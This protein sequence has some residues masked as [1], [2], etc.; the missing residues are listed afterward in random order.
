MAITRLPLIA[1]NW[2]MNGVKKHANKL[3]GSLAK[4][5]R[6]QKKQKFEML[7]CPPAP[8]I[9][10]VVEA[11]RGTGIAV[12]SQDC[13]FENAGAYTGEMSAELLKS[14]E[15]KYVILGH[16]ERRTLNKETDAVILNKATTA[17]KV[18]LRTIICI[19]E[20]L[21]QREAGRTKS[22]NRKQ[23][24]NSLPHQATAKNTV[25]AYEPVWAIGTGKVAS[26]DQAQDMH[27][28]IRAELYKLVGP[29]EAD[30]MRIVY[31]GSM[32]PINAREL[33]AL[34][35]VDGGLIGGASLIVKDF[36]SIGQA[37]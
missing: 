18:G 19:G 34:P 21:K 27:Q 9:G 12:G 3:A 30:E 36:W 37:V 8:L 11:V 16:S 17:H 10:P 7:I 32:N 23:L 20:T 35:D 13:H 22:V 33:L 28:M 6:N 14:M 24:I 1:G 31:G 2:K 15:C 29:A 4:R 5:F 25:I 26:P